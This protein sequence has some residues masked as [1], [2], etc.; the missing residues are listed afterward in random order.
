MTSYPFCRG[1]V[2]ATEIKPNAVIISA[3]VPLANMFG[4][5]T[6]LRSLT[7]GQATFSMEFFCYRRTPTSVQ[8]EV[9]EQVR[10]DNL[11]PKK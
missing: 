6:D 7:R 11:H 4:Y 2:T 9:I 10:K 8:A 1:F 3:E 5:A